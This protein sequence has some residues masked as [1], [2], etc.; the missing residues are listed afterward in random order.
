ME[1]L[2]TNRRTPR[3]LKRSLLVLASV[4]L[5]CFSTLAIAEPRAS[6]QEQQPAPIERRPPPPARLPATSPTGVYVQPAPSPAPAPIER[7]QPPRGEHLAQWMDQHRN[8]TPQQ[9]QQALGHEPGFNALPA[10]TQQRMRERLAQLDAMNPK[11]RDRLLERN[12]FMERLTLPERAEVRGAL[13][14]LGSLPMDERMTVARLFN[15]LRDLPADQRVPALNSGRFGPPLN[16]SQRA[17]LSNL[18]RV[19]PMLPPPHAG[20]QVQAP[21][22]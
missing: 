2:E 6:G 19:E 16:A 20:Q 8:L 18:L 22:R 17:V 14:Q 4:F 10:E 11:K 21:V 15:S 12:E 3:E 1:R 13:A 5:F 7:R 9:Q